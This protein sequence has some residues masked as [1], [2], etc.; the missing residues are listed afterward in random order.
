M[1]D[2]ITQ[3]DYKH[4]ILICLDLESIASKKYQNQHYKTDM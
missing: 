4:T 1:K 2:D 3:Q